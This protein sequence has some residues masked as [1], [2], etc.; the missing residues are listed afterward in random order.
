MKRTKALPLC[1]LSLLSLTLISCGVGKNGGE[2]NTIQNEEFISSDY[3]TPHVN[4]YPYE[5]KSSYMI[6]Y[7]VLNEDIIDEAKQYKVFILHPRM[8]DVTRD[9]VQEIR[10]SGT[11]VLGYI[12]IG[13]DLRT[14]N[15][16]PEEILLDD[17]FIGD[18][19]GPHVDPRPA[20]TTAL[21]DVN[22]IGVSS[23]GGTG[24]ASYFL[25]DN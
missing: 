2:T 3:D 4:K 11:I 5:T 9:Q 15:L 6:Y 12:S 20:G 17:R 14:A 21:D 25:D 23:P 10:G 19:T 7:G 18:G 24:Y 22:P 16:T 8:G 13:E 1:L